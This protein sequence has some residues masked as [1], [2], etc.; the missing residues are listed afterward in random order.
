[1]HEFRRVFLRAAVAGAVLLAGVSS[2][3][4]QSALD[5]IAKTKVVRIG[6]PADYPPYGFVGPDMQPQ[7]LDVDMA[8]Y[9]GA[10][11]GARVELVPVS[12]TNRIP[13]L[14]SGKVEIMVSTLARNAE[15]EKVIDFTKTAYSP[16]ISGVYA[17]KDL[18]I[19]GM[20][21]LAGKSIGVTRGTIEDQTVTGLLPADAK[22]LRFEDHASTMSAFASGQVAAVGISQPAVEALLHRNPE[23]AI[24]YKLPISLSPNFIGLPKGDPALLDKVEQIVREARN[25]GEVERLSV[26]WLKR[27]AGDLPR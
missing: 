26:K 9:I 5:Q 3:H 8:R 1:M 13:Y 10:A 18:S 25:S 20:A 11:L 7:G 17:G 6:V 23:L 2:S 16:F 12:S 21:D 14:Q 22:I 27:P 19:K 15:R 4:A 24:E